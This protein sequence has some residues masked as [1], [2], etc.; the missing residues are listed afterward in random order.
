MMRLHKRRS[1]GRGDIPLTKPLKGPK[2]ALASPVVF[3]G[4]P[5][6]IPA[7][8]SDVFERRA[9]DG[10]TLAKSIHGSFEVRRIPGRDDGDHGIQIAGAI[11]LIF[12]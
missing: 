3:A 5:D 8:R 4:E 2:L 7:E 12:V 11:A 10:K 1:M 6:V 9:V